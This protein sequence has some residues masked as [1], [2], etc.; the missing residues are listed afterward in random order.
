[1]EVLLVYFYTKMGRLKLV[2]SDT[3]ITRLLLDIIT[4]LMLKCYA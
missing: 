1:M 4:F 2:M 3:Y